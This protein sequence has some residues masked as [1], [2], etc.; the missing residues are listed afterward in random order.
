MPDDL[1]L[2]SIIWPITFPDPAVW[3]FKARCLS[4]LG[5]F[6]LAFHMVNVLTRVTRVTGNDNSMSMES[7]LLVLSPL[8]ELQSDSDQHK[9]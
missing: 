8:P 7:K 3:P 5:D 4:S 9:Q 1:T 2:K 6:H